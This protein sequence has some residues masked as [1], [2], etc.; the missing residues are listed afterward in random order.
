MIST[1]KSD[2]P[3]DHTEDESTLSHHLN[4]ALLVAAGI[5]PE[6]PAP[7]PE[8][9]KEGKPAPPPPSAPPVRDPS[10][11]PG[12]VDVVVGK[13]G[14]PQGIYESPSTHVT[15]TANDDASSTTSIPQ[16]PGTMLF[17]SS[18]ISQSREGHRETVLAL[19]D[20][21]VVVDVDNSR[22]GAEGVL[23][24]LVARTRE[25]TG[26]G[27]RTWTLPYRAVVLLCTSLPSPSAVHRLIS[28]SARTRLS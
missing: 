26:E 15:T 11:Q 1:G 9:K 14:L 4:R 10:K 24:D 25:G 19:P 21:K 2:W 18:L 28:S 27:R 17:S 5:P 12:E 13:N 8:A 7:K 6:A 20:W 3:H 23:R 16:Q 22:A